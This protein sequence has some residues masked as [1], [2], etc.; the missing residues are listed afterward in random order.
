[1]KQL[2]VGCGHDIREGWINLDAYALPGVD[3]VHD[4]ERLPLPFPNDEFDTIMARDV[5]EHLEYPPVLRDLHRILKPGGRIVI[6]VPHFTSAGNFIDPT[7]RKLFS[8]QT[9]E[10]FVHHSTF[11]RNYYFDFAFSRIELRRIS[12]PRGLLLCNYLIEPFVN[13][14]DRTRKLY[15]STFL[16]RL[17][18]AMN[19]N[20]VLIK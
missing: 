19:I 7:H 2:N 14:N 15:E 17:F 11:R 9:F 1:M 12:F 18:P 6:Q 16:S 13:I 8:F 3:V 5:L 4:I 20:V 10:F